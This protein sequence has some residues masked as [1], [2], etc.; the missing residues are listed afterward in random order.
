MVITHNSNA[1]EKWQAKNLYRKLLPK[2]SKK[3]L[4]NFIKI[5]LDDFIVYNDM[6]NHL[7]KLRL[8]FQKCK[9]YGISLI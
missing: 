1:Q 2:L 9:I 3:Y 7:Q 6:D 8:C 4:D 5:I